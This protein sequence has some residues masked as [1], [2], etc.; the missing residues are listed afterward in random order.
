M[1]RLA[2]RGQHPRPDV[3]GHPH[4]HGDAYDDRY[5]DRDGL[6]NADRHAA[7]ERRELYYA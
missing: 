7:A 1:R 3:P 6:G 4:E 5:R 2:V